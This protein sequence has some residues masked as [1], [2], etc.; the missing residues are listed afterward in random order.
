MI[1]AEKGAYVLV[2]RGTYL[3]WRART[4]LAPHVEGDPSFRNLYSVMEVNPERFPKVNHD[5]A[6]AFSEFLL[7]SEAQEIIGRFGVSEFGQPLFFPDAGKSEET[8][9]G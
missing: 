8:I 7:G 1:A 5:G 2:D 9:A 3:A 4:D 6:R